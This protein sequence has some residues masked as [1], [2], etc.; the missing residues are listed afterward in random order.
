MTESHRR[1][2]SHGTDAQSTINTK[3]LSAFQNDDDLVVS[4]PEVVSSAVDDVPVGDDQVE[5]VDEESCVR[6]MNE[7]LLQ[8][9]QH[10]HQQ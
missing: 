5:E 6:E 8:Q 4:E 1:R 3:K 2:T 7:E 10:R 9:S